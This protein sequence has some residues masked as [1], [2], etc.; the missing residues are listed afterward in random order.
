MLIILHALLVCAFIAVCAGWALSLRLRLGANSNYKFI[1]HAIVLSA[2]FMLW[3]VVNKYPTTSLFGIFSMICFL[4]LLYSFFS[5]SAL[6]V[7]SLNSYIHD[8]RGPPDL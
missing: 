7:N 3:I 6:I 8:R 5:G 2:G 1:A 4:S